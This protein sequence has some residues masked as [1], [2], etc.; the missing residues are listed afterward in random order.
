GEGLGLSI[1][2]KIVDRHHGEVRVESEV[3]KGS[4]FYVSLPTAPEN[5]SLAP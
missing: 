3:G 1:V 2:R 4:R 5:G